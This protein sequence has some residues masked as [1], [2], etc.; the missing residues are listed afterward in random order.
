MGNVIMSAD[1]LENPWD[2]SLLF[3]FARYGMCVHEICAVEAEWW[4]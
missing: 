4:V 2:R 1:G 3:E